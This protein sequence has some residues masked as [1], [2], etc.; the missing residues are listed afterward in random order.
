M[1]K[2]QNKPFTCTDLE[3]C[4]TVAERIRKLRQEIGLARLKIESILNKK[5][6]ADQIEKMAQEKFEES[7]FL[8]RELERSLE[9][10][11]NMKKFENELF[12]FNNENSL[13]RNK[14]HSQARRSTMLRVEKLKSLTGAEDDIMNDNLGI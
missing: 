2:Q 9:K 13:Q 6:P 7:K 1:K 10:Q 8:I 5:L 11:I 12:K 4:Q 14:S 3:E